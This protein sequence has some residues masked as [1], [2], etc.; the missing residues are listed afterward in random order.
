MSHITKLLLLVLC[1]IDNSFAMGMDIP[2]QELRNKVARLQYVTV[3]TYKQPYTEHDPIVDKRIQ[4]SARDIDRLDSP[5]L[6]LVIDWIQSENPPAIPLYEVDATTLHLML[7]IQQAFPNVPE[8]IDTIGKS[9]LPLL[10]AW[11][12]LQMSPQYLAPVLAEIS[13]QSLHAT[14]IQLSHSETLGENS[15]VRHMLFN[16]L[17][18]RLQWQVTDQ[19][20]MDEDVSVKGCSADG[21]KIVGLNS[22]SHTAFILEKNEIGIWQKFHVQ[23]PELFILNIAISSNGNRVITLNGYCSGGPDRISHFSIGEKKHNAWIFLP[24]LRLHNILSEVALSEDGSLI[25]SKT[26]NNELYSIYHAEGF[27]WIQEFPGENPVH[28][29][30]L[31]GNGTRLAI[32][33][34]FNNVIKIGQYHDQQWNFVSTIQADEQDLCLAISFDGKTVASYSWN[35]KKITLWQECDNPHSWIPTSHYVDHIVKAAFAK[36][37]NRLAMLCGNNVQNT[38]QLWHKENNQWHAKKPITQDEVMDQAIHSIAFSAQGTHLIA[39]LS[40]GTIALFQYPES[41]EE[42]DSDPKVTFQTIPKSSF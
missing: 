15:A 35:S 2:T 13:N 42:W 28:H 16:N 6:Y 34:R 17:T 19:L 14:C 27:S 38:I 31:S 3:Q 23:D 20:E 5:V 29:F 4:L 22:T 30:A 37:G 24:K 40:N 9:L 21:T 41:S 11:D 36:D 10:L 7:C 26:R 25:I 1:I 32:S 39:G 12:Y 33:S 8:E 18:A